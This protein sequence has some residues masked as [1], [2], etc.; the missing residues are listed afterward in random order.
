MGNEE[1]DAVAAAPGQDSI[2]EEPEAEAA[3]EAAAKEDPAP[4]E[5]AAEA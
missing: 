5:V 4:A 3:A 1:K 2:A